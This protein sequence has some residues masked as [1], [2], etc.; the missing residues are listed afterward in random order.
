MKFHKILSYYYRSYGKQGAHF[1]ISPRATGIESLNKWNAGGITDSVVS[2]C[3]QL[4]SNRFGG[5]FGGKGWIINPDGKVLG[6][7]DESKPFITLSVD[8]AES[9]IAKKT[10]PRYIS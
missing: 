3:F 10:Y 7:T 2:G 1:V 6:S 8:L 9:E 4:S 5:Q